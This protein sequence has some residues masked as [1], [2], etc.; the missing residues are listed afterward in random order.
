[1]KK[2]SIFSLLTISEQFATRTYCWSVIEGFTLTL[3]NF[4]PLQADLSDLALYF[5]ELSAIWGK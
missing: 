5:F 1:M 2:I 3:F 4:E